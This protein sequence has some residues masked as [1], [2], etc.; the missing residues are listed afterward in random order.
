MSGIIT[1][2]QGRSSGLV[3]AAAGG[4]AMTLLSATTLGSDAATIDT[5]DVFSTT[6]DCYKVFILNMTS[7]ASAHYG[8]RYLVDGTEQTGNYMAL[9]DGTYKTSLADAAGVEWD[10][11]RYQNYFHGGGWDFNNSNHAS[12][13]EITFFEPNGGA[14]YNQFHGQSMLMQATDYPVTWQWSCWYTAN[15]NATGFRLIMSAS[16]NIIAGCKIYV[17][18]YNKT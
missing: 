5:D 2:N 12:Q 17:Y 11:G 18:G 9:G 15:I 8:I 13:H 6:Y 4:G 7:N 3:K 14:E 1:D 10:N 16:Q